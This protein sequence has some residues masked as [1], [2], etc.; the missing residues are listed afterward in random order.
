[1]RF[2]ALIDDPE[3]FNDLSLA[4]TSAV[5]FSENETIT[6]KILPDAIYF[7]CRTEL[8][9][10]G[11]FMEIRLSETEIF[12]SYRME[13]ASTE[14]N[15]IVMT[16]IGSEFVRLVKEVKDKVRLKLVKRNNQPMLNAE[17]KNEEDL[18]KF[19]PVTI[20]KSTEIVDFLTPT[21]NAPIVGLFIKQIDTFK[22]II[23]AFI[24]LN[25]E[26]VEMK[27]YPEG[28]LHIKGETESNSQ[29]RI[30]FDEL[31][32]MEEIE[33]AE[34]SDVFRIRV[35][36]V[37]KFLGCIPAETKR[38]SIRVTDLNQIVICVKHSNLEYYFYMSSVI[39]DSFY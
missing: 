4:A 21:I 26:T 28:E 19:F 18:S 15:H 10:T 38:F 20:C 9:H 24:A 3:S 11:Y 22:D 35:N 7:V 34:E 29:Y 27:L 25:I 17:V 37:Y 16:M 31:T 8:R 36:D 30:I 2:S 39:P 12:S 33:G 14:N 32:F 13:G 6:L 5:H 23:E 1:M